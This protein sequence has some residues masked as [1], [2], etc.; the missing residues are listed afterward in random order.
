MAGYVNNGE[1]QDYFSAPPGQMS[2][3]F[4]IPPGQDFAPEL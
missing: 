1:Q 2:Y 4:E 3:N